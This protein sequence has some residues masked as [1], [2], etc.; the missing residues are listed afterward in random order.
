MK[1]VRIDVRRYS[2]PFSRPFHYSEGILRKREGYIITAHSADGMTGEGEAAPLPGFSKETLT[3]IETKL[4]NFGAVLPIEVPVE[5]RSDF[6][7]W[8]IAFN[9]FPSLRCAL[10]QA[11]L[12][13]LFQTGVKP[14][15]YFNRRIK[16]SI[17]VN[18]IIG[19]A[20]P[21][22]INK[23]AK[24]LIKKGF[25]TIKMKIGE[26]SVDADVIAV[27]SLRMIAPGIK[28]RLDCNGTWTPNEAA[29][30]LYRFEPFTIEFIEQPT[31]IIAAYRPLKT[32]TKIPL[33]VDEAVRTLEDAEYI[34]EQKLADI[35]VIKP[36][37]T[38]GILQSLEILQAAERAGIRT[39]ITSTFE[40]NIGYRSAVLLAAMNKNSYACGLG[41]A[42]LFVENTDINRYPIRKGSIA[43]KKLFL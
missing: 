24:E 16:S 9:K 28:I 30:N 29:E 1:I 19:S 43:I 21:D 11:F 32:V 25:T 12:S 34:I 38:G 5:N 4:K 7:R 23:Q 15:D 3:E 20:D 31:D 27:N 37:L 33:A 42:G 39:V 26:N 41:T 22:E 2:L 18:G 17:S 10:E 40:S 6:Q 13:L 14:A 35:I 36:M 8:L